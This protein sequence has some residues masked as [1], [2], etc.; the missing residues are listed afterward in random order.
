MPA[1]DSILTDHVAED[2]DHGSESE[3]SEWSFA[4]LSNDQESQ[5]TNRDILMVVILSISIILNLQFLTLILRFNGF[6]FFYC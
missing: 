1:Q 2:D 4:S 3:P 6:E 5:T